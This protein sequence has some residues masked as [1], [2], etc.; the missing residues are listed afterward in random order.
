M[1]RPE[2][3]VA[4][5]SG[6]APGQGRAAAPRFAAG[7]ALVAG[8]IFHADAGARTALFPASEQA[9]YIT[10]ADREEPRT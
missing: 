4:L 6:T 3:E 2:G 8:G 9:A 1:R 7:G 10:G 5:I